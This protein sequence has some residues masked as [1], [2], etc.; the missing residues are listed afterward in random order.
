MDKENRKNGR[1]RIRYNFF[2]LQR[3]RI[4]RSEKLK[5]RQSV[6]SFNTSYI[7]FLFCSNAVNGKQCLEH[8]KDVESESKIFYLH[9]HR[10]SWTTFHVQ[11]IPVSM[12]NDISI[13]LEVLCLERRV[14]RN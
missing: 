2:H 14:V 13:K 6:K 3:H 7:Q 1:S 4:R 12:L 10:H 11:T 5:T 9:L 8:R